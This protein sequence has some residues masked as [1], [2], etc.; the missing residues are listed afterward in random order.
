MQKQIK[1]AAGFFKKLRSIMNE[2]W[3]DK[4]TYIKNC[5][6][7]N[8]YIELSIMCSDMIITITIMKR[9][10]FSVLQN[11]KDNKAH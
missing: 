1:L 4:M 10:I 6:L 9:N 11:I 3:R 7:K 5:I 8:K 2:E